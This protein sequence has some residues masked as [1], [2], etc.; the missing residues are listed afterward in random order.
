VNIKGQ[1]CVKDGGFG[2]LDGSDL[3]SNGPPKFSTDVVSINPLT[4][5]ILVLALL[6]FLLEPIITLRLRSKSVEHA[7]VFLAEFLI[8]DEN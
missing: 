1:Y 6:L 4:S 7:K 5:K 2:Y 3:S 8:Q